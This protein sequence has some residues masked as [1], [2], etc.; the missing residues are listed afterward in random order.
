MEGHSSNNNLY[1][2]LGIQKTATPEEVKKAYRKLALKYHPDKNPNSA[3][4]FKEISY[5][6]EVLGDDQK[7]RVYD[8]YGEL[9]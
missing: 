6:Y 2:V 3:D 1:Q 9:G 5:A 8:R 7:R 4:K